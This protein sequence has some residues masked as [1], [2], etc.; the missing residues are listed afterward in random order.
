[1]EWV[2]CHA[3]TQWNTTQQVLK[4]T[5]CQKIE[6]SQKHNVRR[7]K[8]SHTKEYVPYGYFYK[9]L[10]QTKLISDLRSQKKTVLVRKQ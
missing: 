1:M 5:L 3:V 7:R 4:S 9:V 8:K 2:N 6:E 10:K